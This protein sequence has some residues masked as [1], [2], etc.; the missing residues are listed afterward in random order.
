MEPTLE[1]SFMST[2]SSSFGSTK[3]LYDAFPMSTPGDRDPFLGVGES[4]YGFGYDYALHSSA[5]VYGPEGDL[6]MP[7]GYNHG[8]PGMESDYDSCST[9][10]GGAS[11]KRRVRI[12]LKSMPASG[13]EGGEWEV[14]IC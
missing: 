14:Q 3:S 6:P 9:T 11:G 5:P 13:G 12:A 10:S 1:A 2:S 4:D 8:S 7:G